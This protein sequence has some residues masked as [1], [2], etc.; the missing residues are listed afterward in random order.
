[1]RYGVGV[2]LVIVTDGAGDAAGAAGA[3]LGLGDATGAGTASGL[4]DCKTEREPVTPGNES[5]KAISMNAAAAPIVIF[6][7]TLAVP[8]GPK[9]VLETLL[10]KRSP[11][12]DLPGCNKMTTISTMHDSMNNPYK[13]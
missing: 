6:E 1:M 13:M 11:A 7:R 3:T 9:A 8:R 12:P 10:E 4:V 2:P 5:I